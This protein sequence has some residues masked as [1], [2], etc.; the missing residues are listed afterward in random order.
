MNI[1]IIKMHYGKPPTQIALK[2]VQNS[3][4][5]NSSTAQSKQKNTIS[6]LV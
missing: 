5:L 4:N 1:P 2:P 3:S 6:I